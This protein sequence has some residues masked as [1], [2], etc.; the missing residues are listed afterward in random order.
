MQF[1]GPFR[2]LALFGAIYFVEGAV[3]TYF[4]TFNILYLR[5]FDLSFTRIGVV[6]GITLRKDLG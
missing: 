5:T 3:L 1:K 4:S 6:G 2:R